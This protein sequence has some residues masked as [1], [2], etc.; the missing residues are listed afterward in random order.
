MSGTLRLLIVGDSDDDAAQVVGELRRCGYEPTFARVATAATMTAA[1]ERQPW[2]VVVADYALPEFGALAALALLRQRGQD[3][4][5]I[6]LSGTVGEEAAVAAMKAGAHDFL[7]KG[8]LARLTPV[9]ERELREVVVRRESRRAEEALRFL[10]EASGMLAASLDYEATLANVVRLAVPM[11]ADWCVIDVLEEHGRTRRVATAHADPAQ[12]ALVE[13]LRRYPPDLNSSHP[14]AQVMV[15]GEPVFASQVADAHLQAIAHDA[16]HLDLLQRLG[17]RSYTVAPLTARGRTLG[18]ITFAG[19]DEQRRYGATGLTLATELARRTA[20]ALDNA[21]LYEAEQQA[22]RVVERTAERATRLQEVSAALSAVFTPAQV[23]E[24]VVEQGRAILGANAGMVL[25][26]GSGLE[27][28]LVHGAGYSPE[29]LDSSRRLAVTTRMPITDAVRTG[30]PVVLSS[31]A[32]QAAHPPAS[33]AAQPSTGDG[34]IAALPLLVEGRMVGGLSLNFTGP[35]E[36]SADDRALMLSLARLSAQALERA[37]LYEAERS[38]RAEA[39]AAQKCS[40]LLAEASWIFSEATLDLRAALEAVTRQ[41]SESLGDGC[42]IQLL[43]DDG[44]ELVPGASYHPDPDVHG[45]IRELLAAAPQRVGEGLAGRVMQ[46]IQPL[47]IPSLRSRQVRATEK[48]ECAPYIERFGI[49]SMLIVPLRVHGRITGTL[50]VVRDRSK[51]PYTRDDQIFLQT[52]ANRVALAVENTRLYRE[53]ADREWR[54]K[55]LVGRLLMA[56]EEERRRV[57]YDLHDGLAQAAAATYQHLQGF[58]HQYRPRAAQAREGLDRV[59]ELARGTV[60]EARRLMADL[61]PTVLDDF[62]L[63]AA[64]RLQAEGLRASGWQV[65]YHE[66]LGGDRLPQAME[67]ALFRVAQEALTN[68]RKH[69]Q[70]AEV[71]ITLERQ[72]QTVRLTVEDPGRGFDQDAVQQGGRLG[73]QIGLPGM[74]ERMAWLGGRCTVESRPGAGTRVVAEVPLPAQRKKSGGD[75]ADEPDG[76]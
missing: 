37:R 12:A 34:A 72:G 22:R 24:V 40:A 71:A 11:L 51:G 16:E 30:E 17:L 54:L 49:H 14:A 1:L 68:V 58:A 3:V 35:R 57:A 74:S 6:V 56:Q 33:A 50:T 28:E 70:T 9:I 13:E 46:T 19:L 10:T 32:A 64:L 41:I 48:P 65:L 76:A 21:H 2:D 31:P 62:G 4:P 60:K 5:F 66:T 42:L 63:A 47:L 29:A 25:L 75:D 44:Q 36:F 23:A 26:T 59:I 18:A 8:R 38:A 61:R 53:L 45:F 7:L 39:Q 69:A 67:T 15:T 27:L 55:D 43:S 52:L 73:E 20:L